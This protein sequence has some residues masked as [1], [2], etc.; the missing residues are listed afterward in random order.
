[1]TD[2][3]QQGALKVLGVE[4]GRFYDAGTEITSTQPLR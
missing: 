4:K 2:E 3:Q 1:M